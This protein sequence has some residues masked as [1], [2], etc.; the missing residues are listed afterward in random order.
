MTAHGD[1]IHRPQTAAKS[2]GTFTGDRGFRLVGKLGDGCHLTT[3]KEPQNQHSN[4]LEGGG[5]GYVTGY[6]GEDH[7]P[8]RY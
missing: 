4:G 5:P 2:P 8:D 6:G 1:Y 7:V 3:A